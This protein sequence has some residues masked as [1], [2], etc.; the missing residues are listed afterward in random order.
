MIDFLEPYRQWCAEL[1]P[2]SNG[3]LIAL[4]PSHTDTKPSL[5]INPKN[6]TYLHKCFVCDESGDSYSVAKDYLS[7][8]DSSKYAIHGTAK[9]EIIPYSNGIPI[10][11]STKKAAT[12]LIPDSIVLE[13]HQTLMDNYKLCDWNIS[14]STAK[15]HAPCISYHVYFACKSVTASVSNSFI[16]ETI[17]F[18]LFLRLVLLL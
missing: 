5:Y 9:S 12:D 3:G 1:I 10:Q 15:A 14:P 8:S 17:G 7:L 11:N 18:I 6:G 2:K 13:Y 4:C 16:S